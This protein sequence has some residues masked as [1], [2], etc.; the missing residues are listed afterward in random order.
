[1]R[2]SLCWYGAC[3]RARVDHM[4]DLQKNEKKVQET[5]LF[6]ENEGKLNKT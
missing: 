6:A 1:M 5:F 3:G 2:A 4:I